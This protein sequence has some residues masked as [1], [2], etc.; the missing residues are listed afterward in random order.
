M[1]RLALVA[2]L[3]SGVA[4]TTGSLA[5]PTP[6][7]ARSPDPGGIRQERQWASRSRSR[8][9]F[10]CALPVE[11]SGRAS[12]PGLRGCTSAVDGQGFRQALDQSGTTQAWGVVAADARL[13]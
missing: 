2:S 6:S 7:R 12:A 13:L 1:L 5:T 10:G 3:V 4:P 11:G 8:Q 9:A